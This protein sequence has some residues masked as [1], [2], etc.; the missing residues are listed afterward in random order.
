[1]FTYSGKTGVLIDSV[2]GGPSEALGWSVASVDDVNGDG[3]C[4]LAA[5]SVANYVLVLS[6]ADGS[7]IW[8]LNH[9]KFPVA[10][11]TSVGGGGD[12]DADGVSDIVVGDPYSHAG[13]HDGGAAWVFSG[14]TGA[15]LYE[16]DSTVKRPDSARA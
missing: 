10:F 9:P 5:G 3:I 7:L 16:F 13:V 4:D 15:V 6:G 11:G 8:K 2:Y 1:V 14:K 12:V